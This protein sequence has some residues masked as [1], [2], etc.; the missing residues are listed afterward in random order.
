MVG[1]S[2]AAGN[3]DVDAIGAYAFHLIEQRTMILLTNKDTIGHDV[4]LG[5]SARPCAG[6]SFAFAQPGT[7]WKLYGFTGSTELCQTGSGTL[8]GSKLVM[9]GLPAMSATVLVIPDE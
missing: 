2:V 1:D 9:H 6:A 7:Q 8:R 5:T 4:A 3:A